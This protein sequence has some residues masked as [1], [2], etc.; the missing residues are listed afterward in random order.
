MSINDDD[1]FKM[2]VLIAKC[3]YQ[4]SQDF[5]F[6]KFSQEAMNKDTYGNAEMSA[7]VRILDGLYCLKNR[8][9]QMAVL[10]LIEVILPEFPDE[11]DV[12]KYREGAPGTTLLEICTP[13]DLAYYICLI[14]LAS[15]SRKELKN[16]ILAHSN[17]VNL[18]S[19]SSDCGLIIEHFL[20]GDCKEF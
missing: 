20:N 2:D 16:T 3:G 7:V 18:T 17:F 5:V 9:Y 14:A 13:T 11:I 19:V 6:Q 12:N 8:N 1:I 10:K 4:A 15:C